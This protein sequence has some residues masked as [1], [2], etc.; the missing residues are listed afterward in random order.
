M[1]ASGSTQPCCLATSVYTTTINTQVCGWAPP[2]QVWTQ[3]VFQF[4]EHPADGPGALRVVFQEEILDQFLLLGVLPLTLPAIR[5]DPGTPLD[6]LLSNGRLLLGGLIHS[7]MSGL[8]PLLQA[9]GVLDRP[10]A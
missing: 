1:A 4:V 5:T 9:V 7:A 2:V 3:Q 10:E 8:Q 6:R